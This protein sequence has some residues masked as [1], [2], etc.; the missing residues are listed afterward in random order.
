VCNSGH[1]DK[2]FMLVLQLETRYRQHGSSGSHW[3]MDWLETSKSVFQWDYPTCFLINLISIQLEEEPSVGL[4]V[5]V[6]LVLGHTVM[7][8]RYKNSPS[9]N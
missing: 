7:P 8:E 3:V 6:M 5:W 1:L 9:R 4:R 2:L